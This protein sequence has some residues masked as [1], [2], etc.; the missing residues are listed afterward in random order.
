MIRRTWLAVLTAGMLLSSCS[1]SARA[2]AEPTSGDSRQVTPAEPLRTMVGALRLEPTSLALR[3]PRETFSNVDH[4]RLFNADI[5]NI[6][7]QSVPRPYLVEALPQLDTDSWRVLPDGRMQT[8][9]HL[10][11]NLLWHDGT[12][13]SAEDFVFSWRVYA[14][15]DVGLWRQPPFDAIEQVQ[16]ADPRT[17]VLSWKR[18]YPDAPHMA[19]RDRNLPALPRHLLEAP[20]AAEPLDAFLAL[21]YWSRDYLGSGPYRMV[22]WEP[23]A[24]IEAAAFD[25]HVTGRPKIDRIKL[26]FISDPN[27][28]LSNMLAG[29][30]HL[31]GATA[32]GITHGVTLQQEWAPRQ[33][34]TV[35]YQ[36]F[37]WRGV[38]LQFLPA[39]TSPRALQDVRV[40]KAMAYALDKGAINETINA[41]L[42]V[43][44]DYLLPPNGQ[45]GAAVQ[46]GAVKYGYDPRLSEQLMREAGF[47]KGPDGVWLHP[48]EGRFNVELRTIAG[49]SSANELAALA[50]DWQKA[51]FEIN[52]RMFPAALGLDPETKA[53]YPGLSLT[54]MP[55]T[56]RTV[57]GPVPGNI[58]TPENRWRGGSQINWTHPEYTRLVELFTST[59]RREERADQMTQMARLF[60]EDVAALSLGFPPIVWAAVSAL[61]GP[62][63]GPPETNVLWNVP[64]WELR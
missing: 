28:A 7:D 55:A 5:A 64:E 3:P 24:F 58:P 6:D 30:L 35:I 56:E 10:R 26:L 44:A 49:G 4:L 1:S 46:R 11:P 47:E 21:S 20:F 13:L 31:A 22:D 40:R 34:G 38:T 19:G 62:K 9:Y 45:W 15:P 50:S 53:G 16:A 32:L 37:I 43:D 8:T 51:G 42:A 25:A 52:Q 36:T 48:A 12:P 60:S 39:L 29:D 61:R 33:A 41:G 59:L 18:L 2:P 27:T 63:A 17:L 14:N 54:S 23:G 57:L